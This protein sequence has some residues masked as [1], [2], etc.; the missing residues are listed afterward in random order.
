MKKLTYNW[1]KRPFIFLVVFPF[2]LFACYQ[3]L[4]ATE[5]YESQ[6]KLLIQE[7]SGGASLDPAVLLLSNFSGGSTG[8]DTEVVKA[9]I[10]SGDMFTYIDGELS[11]IHI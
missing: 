5:R 11:L 9:F 1:I 10:L 6:M 2:L 4:F 8:N 3:L 7:P